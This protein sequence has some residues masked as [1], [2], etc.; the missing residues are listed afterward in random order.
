MPP[1]LFP[2][3]LTLDYPQEMAISGMQW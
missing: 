2:T 1:R 3:L